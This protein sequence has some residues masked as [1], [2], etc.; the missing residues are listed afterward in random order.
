MEEPYAV[1]CAMDT[2]NKTYHRNILVRNGS[3]RIAIITSDYVIKFDYDYENVEEIGGCEQE[4]ELYKLAVEDGID[5]LFA[6]TERYDYNGHSFYIMP[7]I[8][9]IGKRRYKKYHPAD[10]YMTSKEKEWC[11]S[12]KLVD[13]HSNNY[14]FRKGKIC[15]VDYAFFQSDADWDDEIY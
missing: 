12:H 2:F 11:D 8:Y 10:Y 4:M 6:K 14:G 13:L 9:G 1:K 7:R 5:Y 15:I 3:A